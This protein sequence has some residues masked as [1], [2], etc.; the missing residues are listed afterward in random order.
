MF[1]LPEI[2]KQNIPPNVYF[3]KTNVTTFGLIVTIC[4]FYPDWNKMLSGL[5][6]WAVN[7]PGP[8]VLK[9]IL[10]KLQP[11]ALIYLVLQYYRRII[12]KTNGNMQVS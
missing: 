3:P 9:T 6:L 8:K 5:K 2:V 12:Y 10:T 7:I 4:L 11:G 1:T